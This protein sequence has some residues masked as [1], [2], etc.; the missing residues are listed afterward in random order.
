MRLKVEMTLNAATAQRFKETAERLATMNI[1]DDGL[2][3][4]TVLLRIAANYDRAAT[5]A[6]KSITVDKLNAENDE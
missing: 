6:G 2:L 3:A 5:E 4:A 1:G